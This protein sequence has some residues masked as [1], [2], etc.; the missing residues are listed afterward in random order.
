MKDFLAFYLGYSISRPLNMPPATRYCLI[1]PCKRVLA[2]KS[3]EKISAMQ[4]QQTLWPHVAQSLSGELPLPQVESKL[5]E[6]VSDTDSGVNPRKEWGK[7]WQRR[8]DSRAMLVKMVVVLKWVWFDGQDA[9][10]HNHKLLGNHRML[11]PV[12][13]SWVTACLVSNVALCNTLRSEETG[14]TEETIN[15]DS[16]SSTYLEV[17]PFPTSSNFQLCFLLESLHPRLGCY[18]G[19]LTIQPCS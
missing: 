3:L 6:P 1:F 12:L 14:K 10:D 4:F 13:L 16:S 9:N 5:S 7:I 15:P 11:W 8:M 17:L 19:C 2:R 18:T